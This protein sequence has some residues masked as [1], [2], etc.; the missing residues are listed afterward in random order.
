M[1][2]VV[3]SFWLGLAML[4]G[5][6]A[7]AVEPDEV[8]DDPVLEQRARE[9]SQEIRCLVCQNEPIDSSDAPIARDLRLLVRAR[10]QAGDS[11]AQVL[12]FLVGRYG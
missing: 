6:I 11:D 8:L 7:G 4:A 3:I 2:A 12:Q 9:L 1:K 5:S 10:L